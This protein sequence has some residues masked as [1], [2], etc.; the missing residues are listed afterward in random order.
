MSGRPSPVPPAVRRARVAATFNEVAEEYDQGGVAW[1]APIARRLVECLAPRPGE[2][3]LDIGCGRGAALFELAE[4]VGTS[5]AVTGIDLAPAMVEAART[6]AR[7]RG[8][9]NVD[10]HVMDAAAPDLARSSYDLATASFVLFFMPAPVAAL[11]AWRRLLAPGG[12]LGVST[13][14]QDDVGLLGDVLR[15]YL[16]EPAFQPPSPFRDDD[17][18]EQVFAAGGFSRIQ[19]Q[20]FDFSVS[21]ADPGEWHSWSW[22]HGQRAVW[23]RVPPAERDH[24]RVVAERHLADLRG[25]DGR[26]ALTQRI[27][28]TTGVRPPGEW[29]TPA[30]PGLRQ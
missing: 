20:A 4:A 10:L 25:Q 21:F 14:D 5:G 7:A 13:Y 1:F 18:V 16:P 12:R 28:L 3:A 8:I 23:E 22:S 11:R 2:R 27:R 19:T 29:E 9:A 26:I 30:P 6:Q 15:P 24:V 17:T